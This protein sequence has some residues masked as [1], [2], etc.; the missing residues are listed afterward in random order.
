MTKQTNLAAHSQ[1]LSQKEPCSPSV[2]NGNCDVYQS[3]IE[4]IIDAVCR[5]NGDEQ[6]L[7]LY[8]LLER[9]LPEPASES[10]AVCDPR[11]TTRV[12]GFFTPHQV[13]MVSDEMQN[14]VAA[15]KEREREDGDELT[16]P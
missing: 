8:L 1:M 7:A 15:L 3:S 12:L 11:D 13:E 10:L 9:L 2:E 4:T 5:R 16:A 14:W 6:R